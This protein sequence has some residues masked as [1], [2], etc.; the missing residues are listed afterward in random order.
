LRAGPRG[1]RASPCGP[2]AYAGRARAGLR[3]QYPGPPRVFFAGLRA[4][5]A[6]QALI[7]IPSCKKFSKPKV[8]VFF[9]CVCVCFS[10][11]NI[12]KLGSGLII[13]V[14]GNSIQLVVKVN[15]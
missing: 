11:M 6:G 12:I 4:G 14:I 15:R 9:F 1:P 8:F 3:A 5:P 10:C 13:K 2:R 7:A